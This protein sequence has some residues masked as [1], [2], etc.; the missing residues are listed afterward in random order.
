M[1]PR[2]EDEGMAQEAP[3]GWRQYGTAVVASM[4]DVLAKA[5]EQHHPLLLETADYWLSLG[6]AIGVSRP[7]EAR[8]LLNLIESD[9]LSRKELAD[10]A[11]SF[12]G[13]VLR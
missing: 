6:L 11:A 5:E 10:D 9:E 12:V 8:Q 1:S 13:E 4:S 7:E 2:E 3:E